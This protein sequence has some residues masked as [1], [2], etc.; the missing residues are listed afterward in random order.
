M[1]SRTTSPSKPSKYLALLSRLL[2]RGKRLGRSIEPSDSRHPEWEIA[3]EMG[4]ELGQFREAEVA[5]FLE[6]ASSH[7]VILRSLLVLQ[8]VPE[9]RRSYRWPQWADVAI[10]SEQKRIHRAIPYLDAIVRTLQA[11]GCKVTVIKS[12]DH[13]PDLGSDLDLFTN[14]ASEKVI[15]IMRTRLNAQPA[16]RSWGDRLAGK[17]NFMVPG[18]QEQVELHV[19]RLGQT[20]EQTSIADSLIACP[21]LAQVGG[22]TFGIARPEDRLMIATLQRMYR[23]FYFRLCDIVDTTELLETETLDYEY[24]ESAADAAGIWQGVASYLS[25]VSGYAKTYRGQGLDLPSAVMS[26][27]R[28]TA[29][30]ISFGRGFLRVPILPQSA[31]LY[32]SELKRLISNGRLTA[33]VRLSLL[34]CLA[35]AAA[36]GYKLTGDD[37]RVW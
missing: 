37:K 21:R 6:L 19:G 30:D 31:S 16:T 4:N 20:G 11:E 17:W 27:A 9:A 24:L 34:P 15:D 35:T 7:H 14:A 25:I 36:L 13:W 1:A 28:L 8:Q 32:A 29:D 3:A 33:S 22:Y 18:L 23:H 26:A 12:L 5:E 10:A 2:L